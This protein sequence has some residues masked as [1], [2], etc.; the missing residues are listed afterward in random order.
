MLNQPE[1]CVAQ[2][3]LKPEFKV[4][5]MQMDKVCLGQVSA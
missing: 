2:S 3:M 4:L 5:K 1:D